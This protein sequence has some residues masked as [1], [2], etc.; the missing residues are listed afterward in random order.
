MGYGGVGST[1]RAVLTLVWSSHLVRWGATKWVGLT[2]VGWTDK[3]VTQ[4]PEG[5]VRVE[6]G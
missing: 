6:P 5:G 3:G 4:S 2:S 1:G